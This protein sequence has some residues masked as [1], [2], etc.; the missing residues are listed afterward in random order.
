MK[1]IVGLALV[2]LTMFSALS[3]KNDNE[4]SGPAAVLGV[5]VKGIE[6]VVEIPRRQSQTLEVQLTSAPGPYNALTVRIGGSAELVEKYNAAHGT[7]YE[8]LP[9]EAY[10]LPAIPFLLPRYNKVSSL[11][12]ITLK[13]AGCVPE[14]I[15]LLPLVPVKVEEDAT[16]EVSEEDAAYILFKMLLPE[17]EGEGTE[18]D[19]YILNNVAGFQKLGAML[20]EGETVYYKLAADMDLEGIEWQSVSCEGNK[21]AFLDGNGHTISHLTAPLFAVLDGTVINLTIDGATIEGTVAD[22]GVLA[23]KAGSANTVNALVAENVTITN[24]TITNTNDRTGGLFG[25][26]LGG[27]VENVEVA[28]TVNGGQQVGGFI[29]RVD[30]GTVVNCSSS[31][32]VT[33]SG[34]YSGG[35]IGLA[36]NVT[37]K[38]CH[39]SGKSVNN[40]SNYSRVGGLIGQ[41]EGGLVEKSYSSVDVEGLGHF[42]GGLIGVVN[43]EV[44]V[45]TSYATG[46]VTLPNSGNKAGAGGLLGRLDKGPVTVTN[47]YCTGALVADRW[48]GAF[49]GNTND[50]TAVDITVTNCF[51]TSD[52]SGIT[53]VKG[54]FIGNTYVSNFNCT[55]FIGWNTTGDPFYG[56]GTTVVATAGNYLGAEGTISSQAATLG[57]STDIWDLSEDVP[58]LK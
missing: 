3:C 1:K 22:M 4:Q 52:I 49:L 45:R 28:T 38:G 31:S 54:V 36:V 13:G 42:A 30:A 12:T 50:K 41:M 23:G 55:G 8:M 37:V 15:Y 17:Q 32:N 33:A 21:K 47:C 57:W 58:V 19:P 26:L 10:D 56:T 44:E 9:A 46:K 51:T 5:S 39:A 7:S 18:D 14:Q 24:S 48:S 6:N 16:Y 34:Y 11:E 43:G 53:R 2:A 20:R 29:G 40:K 27:V 35:F 25:Y